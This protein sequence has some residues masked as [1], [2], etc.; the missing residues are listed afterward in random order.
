MSQFSFFKRKKRLIVQASLRQICSN[1]SISG[2]KKLSLSFCF[3]KEYDH[4]SVVTKSRRRIDTLK[5][6]TKEFDN[7]DNFYADS[8]VRKLWNDQLDSG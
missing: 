5:Y 1:K 6:V 2:G 4:P 8:N 7:W 3:R